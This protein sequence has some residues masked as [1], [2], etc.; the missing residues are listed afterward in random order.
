MMDFN[1]QLVKNSINIELEVDNK[2]RFPYI[3]DVPINA[4]VPVE[5]EKALFTDCVEVSNLHFFY[6]VQPTNIDSIMSYWDAIDSPLK[7]KVKNFLRFVQGPKRANNDNPSV[8]Q[9]W[10]T[11]VSRIPGLIYKKKS[12]PS[13]DHY[14]V[15]FKAGWFNYLKAIVYLKNDKEVWDKLNELKALLTDVEKSLP[16]MKT[17]TVECFSKLAGEKL[18]SIT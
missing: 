10:A 11:I 9:I 16:E 8:R 3:V 12:D 17:K 13:L 7:E 6:M 18:Q 15:E 1:H 2:Q 14:D 4:H 5:I